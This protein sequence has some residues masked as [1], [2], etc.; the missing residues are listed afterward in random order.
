MRTLLAAAT[1]L[2]ALSLS[3][4]ALAGSPLYTALTTTSD[5]EA[6]YLA[7]KARARDRYKSARAECR[8]LASGEQP[9][10]VKQARA[11]RSKAASEAKSVYWKA[12][13]DEA[14]SAASRS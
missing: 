12:L 11:A 3:T 10:C 13:S 7:A 5:A 14:R 1:A 4:G 2:L 6:E 8:K 9:A